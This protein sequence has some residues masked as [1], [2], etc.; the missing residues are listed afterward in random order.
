MTGFVPHK[1]T[2]LANGLPPTSAFEPLWVRWGENLHS[3][4]TGGLTRIKGNSAASVSALD[5]RT[6]ETQ[7]SKTN[8]QETP[9]SSGNSQELK[10][11]QSWSDESFIYQT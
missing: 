9:V 11:Y 10:L 6:A 5:R 8:E 4:G 7:S 3:R 1:A 2:V